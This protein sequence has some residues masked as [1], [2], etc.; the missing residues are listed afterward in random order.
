MRDHDRVSYQKIGFLSHCRQTLRLQSRGTF[1]TE[2][3]AVVN[4]HRFQMQC[5]RVLPYNDG[6]EKS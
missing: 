4:R 3:L 1:A 6:F 2:I 5:I